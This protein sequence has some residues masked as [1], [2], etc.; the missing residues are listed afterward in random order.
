MN[1][2]IPSAQELSLR[3]QRLSHQQLIGLASSSGV[4]FTTLAA[5][6]RGATKD[7]R[8]ETVRKFWPDLLAL[9]GAG[10]QG[11]RDLGERT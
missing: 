6:Q 9:T 1:S 8:V 7:P 3:L 10:E 5:V 2:D 4:P 11:E